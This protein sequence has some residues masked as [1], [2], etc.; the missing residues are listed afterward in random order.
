MS[1]KIRIQKQTTQKFIY[2][3]TTGSVNNLALKLFNEKLALKLF[4]EKTKLITS[5]LLYCRYPVFRPRILQDGTS[6]DSDERLEMTPPFNPILLH[7]TIKKTV[8]WI[9]IRINFD[10]AIRNQDG[11]NDPQ[12]QTKVE[13]FYVLKCWMFP[14]K[15]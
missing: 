7:L 2:V 14:F 6:T 4:N 9:R 15:R 10:R 12:K 13:T 11:E 5:S 3:K 1:N 8:L